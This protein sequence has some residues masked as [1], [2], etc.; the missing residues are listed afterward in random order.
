MC[1]AP[2]GADY[3]LNAPWNEKEPLQE[4]FVVDITLSRKFKMKLQVDEN[5]EILDGQEDYIKNWAKY[6]AESYGSELID[7]NIL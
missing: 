6:V 7:F 3:E 4:E 2:L 1:N 5:G